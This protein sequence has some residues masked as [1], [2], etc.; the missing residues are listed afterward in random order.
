MFVRENGLRGFKGA[1]YGVVGLSVRKRFVH[2]DSSLY[3]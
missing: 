1:G 2:T 3:R